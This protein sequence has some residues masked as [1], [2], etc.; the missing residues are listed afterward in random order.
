[1]FRG[2]TGYIEQMDVIGNKTFIEFVEQ[3]EREEDIELETFKI[4]DRVHIVT[5]APDPQ[6]MEMDITIPVLSPILIRKKSLAEEIAELD[7]S[8]L[9]CPVL[10]RRQDDSAAKTFRYEG[11]DLITLQKLVERDYSG[12]M[13]PPRFFWML[14]HPGPTQHV[15]ATHSALDTAWQPNG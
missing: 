11:Y 4:G 14:Y 15:R 3:L 1:M 8:A 6:K 9:D 12:S 5:I 2:A 13:V 10:P 7:V